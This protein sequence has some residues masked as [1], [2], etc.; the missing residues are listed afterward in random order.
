VFGQKA[1]VLRRPS[2]LAGVLVI[3][4]PRLT[5]L[6]GGIAADALS[7]LLALLTSILIG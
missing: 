6:V 5:M 3:R 1:S 2:R 4:L 7:L